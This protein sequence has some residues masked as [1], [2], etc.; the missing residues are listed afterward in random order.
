[1]L[2]SINAMGH[3]HQWQ[4][5]PPGGK[6]EW[7]KSWDERYGDEE[8][9]ASNAM[10]NCPEEIQ[11]L[12]QLLKKDPSYETSSS[13]PHLVEW[14]SSCTST[15]TVRFVLPKEEAEVVEEET[16]AEAVAAKVSEEKKS[17]EAV[18]A[19]TQTPS[20]KLKRRGGRGSRMRRMLAF[21]LQLTVKQGL[22]LS[23]LLKLDT[24]SKFKEESVS[25]Q[26][27]AKR[28]RVKME[29][30]Q[31]KE[32]IVEHTVKEEKVEESC[33]GKEVP[34]SGSTNFTLSSFPT[35]VNPP[36]AQPLPHG[37][38][39]PPSPVVS[40][41]LFSSPLLTP[42]CI[43]LHQSPQFGQMPAANWVICGG[44]QMLGTV[45][46]FWAAPMPTAQ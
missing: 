15:R 41:P 7:S 44:C 24:N 6:L 42:P 36:S 4:S 21:Q 33:P 28:V 26:K 32:E 13:W 19:C 25:P 43:P 35:G 9:M 2:A 17:C 27:K 1:M 37:P 11:Q 45:I 20:Q 10:F 22:P 18:D 8:D 29:K 38:C 31:D 3:H 5:E 46:P 23:R 34:S 16:E 39:L 30:R 40:P 14:C 12:R